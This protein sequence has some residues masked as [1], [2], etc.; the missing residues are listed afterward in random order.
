[1]SG[2]LGGFS[3]SLWV[4]ECPCGARNE[5]DLPPHVYQLARQFSLGHCHACGREYIISVSVARTVPDLH[6]DPERWGPRA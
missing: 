1:M 5:F 6:D 2:M 3:G 4:G